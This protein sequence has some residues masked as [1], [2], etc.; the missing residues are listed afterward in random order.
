M[1]G[2]VRNPSH[3]EK[4]RPVMVEV[5]RLSGTSFQYS[6]GKWK[7]IQMENIK[8]EKLGDKDST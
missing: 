6:T 5:N 8:K 4:F 7:Q 3:A 2:W 1:V